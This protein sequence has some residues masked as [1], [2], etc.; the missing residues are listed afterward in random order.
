MDFNLMTFVCDQCTMS[1]GAPHEVV[2]NEDAENVKG[3][4]D[5]ME[6][7]NRQTRFIREGLKKSEGM[8]LPAY[9]QSTSRTLTWG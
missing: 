2:L 8:V 4:K 3:S 1:P 7:F 9:V 6:R 5:R